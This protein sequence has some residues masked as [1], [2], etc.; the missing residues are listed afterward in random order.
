M[1]TAPTLVC[2]FARVGDLVMFT[3]VLKALAA[4]GPLE[5]CARPWAAPLLAAEPC[6]A[7]IHTIAKPDP[8][9]WQELLAGRPRAALTARLRARGYGRIIILDRETPGIARW[10]RAWAGTTPIL[11][12]PHIAQGTAGHLVDANIAAAEAAGITVA[13]RAP[14]LTVPA[15]RLTTAEGLLAPLGR[16]VVAVQA[17]SSLT[18]RWLRRQ[19]NLKGLEA[20]QWAR[21]LTRM[22]GDDEADAVVLLGSAP[23]GRE[24]RAIRALVPAGL[25][26]R[27][28]D[29]TGKVGLADLPAVLARCTAVLS[30]DTGPAHI[31]AAVGT[32]LL[33]L[34]G[35]TDPRRFLARGP[36][37]IELLLGSAP[38][39]FCHGTR[40]F[41]TCREN[42]CLSELDDAAIHA[43]WERL[44]TAAPAPRS[45]V[46]APDR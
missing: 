6:L 44:R 21:L 33:A 37:R 22:L 11:V 2:Y 5:L 41:R 10:I 8:P 20:G 43:A 3:P 26:H 36:G 14:T 16:R 46:A 45:A 25:I 7:A 18:H 42:R 31:A 12:L 35:P 30:V 4:Q 38:C 27:V 34:F 1:S 24:A 29:W 28:H 9:W 15:S 32:P 13:D 39:Q 19:P 17:G 40:L 23:E